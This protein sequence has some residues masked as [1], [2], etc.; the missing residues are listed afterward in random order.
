MLKRIFPKVYDNK[1]VEQPI[2]YHPFDVYTHTLL[3]LYHLQALSTDKLLRYAALYHDVGKVEQYSTYD[4]KLD[5]EGIRNMFS[6]WLNH[7]NCGEDFVRE[8]FRL[9]G[10]SN[11]EI[12]IIAWYVH[13]HMKLGEIL[14]GDSRHY[15]KKLRPL[16]AEV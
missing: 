8:D 2:R 10:T 3:V 11:K 6:S 7:I 13:N 12:D 5:E 14:M 1:G 16:I 9:L 15:T 4:M